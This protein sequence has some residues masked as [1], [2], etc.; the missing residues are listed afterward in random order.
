MHHLLAGYNA[1]VASAAVDTQVD[2]VAD[3][4]VTIN[5]GRF[6]LPK[7]KKVLAGYAS[8]L[9]LNRMKVDAPTFQNWALP[10]IEPVD[11]TA[12]LGDEPTVYMP[13]ES[14]FL[15]PGL[16]NVSLQASRDVA[17]AAP[18]YW[19]LW[20]GD[21]YPAPI[22]VPCTTVYATAAVVAA[23]AGVWA[24]GALTFNRALP[25]GRYKVV[26]MNAIGANLLFARL[27]YPQF[28]ERP[29]VI[30]MDAS[31]SDIYRYWRYGNFGD[32]GEFM[33][34]SPPQLEVLGTGVT[35]TQAVYLE[36]IKVG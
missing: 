33:N 17:G 13:E 35:T 5:S 25:S 24:L 1:T 19:G 3:P 32:F 4:T 31:S 10:Y 16:E 36:L 12:L 28:I 9:S 8:G 21:G 11:A 23:A 27:V 26:G 29:G 7:P 20:L 22:K 2:V 30:G 15:L 14:G 6:M 34:T 18:V